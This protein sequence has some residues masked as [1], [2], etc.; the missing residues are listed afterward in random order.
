MPRSPDQATRARKLAN[1]C[2]TVGASV[3]GGYLDVLSCCVGM[4]CMR[5]RMLRALQ[6]IAVALTA[7][8]IHSRT[9]RVIAVRAAMPCHAALLA[10]LLRSH[11]DEPTR[12]RAGP[13]YTA[14]RA[15]TYRSLSVPLQ[16]QATLTDECGPRQTGSEPVSDLV[17]RPC[18]VASWHAEQR[19]A[20]H[21]A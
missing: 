4:P 10:V 17:R 19:A 3:S 13:C 11:R 18:S 12:L 9:F 20:W 1:A 5:L 2:A 6:Q 14:G 16:V 21:A 7:S 8:A 15:F